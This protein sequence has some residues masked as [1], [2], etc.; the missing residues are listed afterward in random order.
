[1]SVKRERREMVI[2]ELAEKIANKYFSD[3]TPINPFLIAGYE[4]INYNHSSFNEEFLGLTQYY[5][6]QVPFHIFINKRQLK[7]LKNTR[8]RSTMGHELGH[9]LINEHKMELEKGNSLSWDGVNN[10]SANKIIEWEAETFSAN[11]LMPRNRFISTCGQYGDGMEAILHASEIF[12]TSISSTAYHYSKCDVSPCISVKWNSKGEIEN[13]W[14]SKGFLKILKNK[15]LLKYNSKRPLTDC[16]L[17]GSQNS[18]LSY[19]QSHTY[20]SSWFLDLESHT[21]PDMLLIEESF[22][23]G[24]HGGVSILRMESYK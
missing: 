3:I 18:K 1:M 14:V 4:G 9:C 22:K 15:L 20:L 7:S 16:K 17:I 10:Y 21:I 2:A 11:L 6:G 12:D 13:Y 5:G 19:N 8:A 23:M 24:E